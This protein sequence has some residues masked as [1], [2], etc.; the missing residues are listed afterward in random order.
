MNNIMITVYPSLAKWGR[1]VL[2]NV[3][4]HGHK[5]KCCSTY[6][7][8]WAFRNKN[9]SGFQMLHRNLQ[10]RKQRLI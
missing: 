2:L 7:Q 5:G 4:L 9:N 8:T 1:C 6:V 10:I 3:N